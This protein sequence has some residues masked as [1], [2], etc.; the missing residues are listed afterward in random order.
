[1]NGSGTIRRHEKFASAFVGAR[2]VD[3][4][5]PP[6]YSKDRRYPVLYMHDGQNLFEPISSIGGVA[7]ELDKA[8]TRLV[9]ANKIPSV[10]VVGVW[11]SAI[12]W[13]EYMPQQAYEAPAFEKKRAEFIEHAGG[14]AISDSYLKFLVEEIKPFVDSTCPTLADQRHT[15][16]M[17]SSMGGLISLYAI[18]KYPD[19][20]FGAGCLSTHWLA[21]LNE[22][23]DEMADLLPAPETHKLYFDYGTLGHDAHYE[24]YQLRMDDHLAR[25]GY[26]ST[27]WITRKYEG[28]DHNETAWRDRVEIPLSFLFSDLI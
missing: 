17:G 21:G 2:N 15:F 19:V 25:A 26:T 5:L 16:I 13:R 7:W 3:I 12:R 9:D 6:D 23:V 14:D 10:I 18:S 28:A 22:L 4:W 20:F 24:A 27:N 11:N 1:M 8:I